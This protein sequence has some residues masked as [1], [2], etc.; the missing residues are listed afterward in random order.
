M[1]SNTEAMIFFGAPCTCIDY[2]L[3]IVDDSWVLTM[4]F[5]IFCQIEMLTRCTLPALN[6]HQMLCCDCNHSNYLRSLTRTCG[7]L[8]QCSACLRWIFSTVLTTS[9][10]ILLRYAAVVVIVIFTTEVAD[11][12]PSLLGEEK[13]HHS[14]HHYLQVSDPLDGI[15]L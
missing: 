15:V 14:F 13:P 7:R 2:Q 10:F 6:Q 12:E 9:I 1:F 4:A 11:P 8:S 5:C 3:F